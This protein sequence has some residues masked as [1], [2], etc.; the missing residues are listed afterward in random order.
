MKKSS[1]ILTVGVGVALT[2]LA[3]FAASKLVKKQ[4]KKEAEKK[5]EERKG[6]INDLS[7]LKLPEETLVEIIESQK[8]GFCEKIHKLFTHSP[9]WS[10][11][12]LDLEKYLEPGCGNA[13]H[14]A[15]S[16]YNNSPQLDIYLVV[17]EYVKK[18]YAFPKIGEFKSHLDSLSRG[19]RCRPFT[20]LE[21]WAVVVDKGGKDSDDQKIIRINPEYYKENRSPKNDGTKEYYELLIRN[22]SSEREKLEEYL[23]TSVVEVALLWRISFRMK[24]ESYKEGI[25]LAE[26]ARVLKSLI[27][28]EIT[29]SNGTSVGYDVIVFHSS[30]PT[31]ETL[32]RDELSMD[33]LALDGTPF[34]VGY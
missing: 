34:T 30:V 19:W 14:V 25:D 1:V 3:I 6:E 23:G 26:A 7:E 33:L 32:R 31:E 17:P 21:L 12:L 2:G 22:N 11:G 5:K 4:E 8:G 29:G 13:I 16:L 9:E 20:M 27:D 10:D 15:Q 24:T 28:G 18:S